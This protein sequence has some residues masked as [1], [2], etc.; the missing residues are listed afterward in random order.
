MRRVPAII[1]ATALALATIVPSA[2]AAGGG[3]ASGFVT[4]VGEG[5]E[6]PGVRTSWF[7]VED[8]GVG[9]ADSGTYR[10]SRSGVGS[11]ALEI[12]CVKVGSKWAEFAGVVTGA[13][14]PY[15]DGEVFLVSVKDGGRGSAADEIGMKSKASIEDG[16]S[17]ALDDRQFGRKGV[18]LGGDIRVRPAR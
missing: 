12:A 6:S 4:W 10:F 13:T 14:G 2:A 11:F 1:S 3:Q 15:T 8:G 17:A 7:H 5:G 16:C 9:G 18:I